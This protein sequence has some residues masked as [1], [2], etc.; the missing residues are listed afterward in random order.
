[1][2]I[3]KLL[4]LIAAVVAMAATQADAPDLKAVQRPMSDLHAVA[5]FSDCR[6]LR[7]GWRSATASGSRTS[8]RTIFR[9]WIRKTNKVGATIPVGKDALRGP[10]DRLRQRVGAHCSDGIGVSAWMQ[11]S[12]KIVA[13]IPSRRRQHRRRN[14]GGRGQ[15]LD[16]FGRRRA[17]CRASI[18]RP[19]K[20]VPNSDSARVPLP[21]SLTGIPCG[22][23]APRT[24]W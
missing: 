18:R 9:S 4:Y 22:S 15:R 20:V 23:P 14:H 3:N 10:R 1:M 8:Q 11:K 17:C 24:I 13:S 16:A 19:I 6:D 5:K 7:I 12:H 21:P 2:K